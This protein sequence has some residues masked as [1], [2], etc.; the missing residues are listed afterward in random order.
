MAG[1]SSTVRRSAK[2][3]FSVIEVMRIKGLQVKEEEMGF[4]LFERER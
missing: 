4:Y 3:A 1:D 2:K